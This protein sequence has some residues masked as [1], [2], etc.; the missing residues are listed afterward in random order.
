[1]RGGGGADA[2][3]G[4]RHACALTF[5]FI[6][7]VWVSP[8]PIDR[9][10]AHTN[11]PSTHHDDGTFQERVASVLMGT[12]EATAAQQVAEAAAQELRA[13][14]EAKEAEVTELSHAR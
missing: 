8:F 9:L 4:G 10:T 3:G 13:A 2:R 1:M 5:C 7:E 12:E 14:L 11:R 6:D